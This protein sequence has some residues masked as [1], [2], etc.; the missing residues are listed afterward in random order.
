MAGAENEFNEHLPQPFRFAVL[1]T[2]GIW[3]WSRNVQVLHRHSIDTAQLIRYPHRLDHHSSFHLALFLTAPLA[4]SWLAYQWTS[5][6]IVPILYLVFLLATFVWPSTP[7]HS[8]RNRFVK[9]LVRISYGGFAFTE[10]GKFGDLLL[11]DALTSYAK[12]LGDFGVMICTAI[13]R[14]E[15]VSGKPDKFCGRGFVMPLC[16][17]WPFVIRFSQCLREHSRLRKEQPGG[18]IS[19]HTLNA[20][21]YATA[22]PP[23]ILSSVDPKEALHDWFFTLWII[24]SIVNA[25]YSFYWDI[26][27][28][29]DLTLFAGEQARSSQYPFG[30]RDTLVFQPATKYYIAIV[31]DVTL[32]FAWSIKLYPALQ[33]FAGMQLG[34]FCLE[35]CEILRRWMWIFLRVEAE[36]LRGRKTEIPL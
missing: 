31:V 25:S 13:T 5:W 32:R 20:A 18:W 9:T 23:I 2:L 19:S 29:W 1:V 14:G 10:D 8:G 24:A 34:I 4:V 3:L 16:L 21:K 33:P 11:S 17:A 12:P 7:S 15:Y 28:D 6:T 35:L 30:L 26:A 27:R 22:F 36:H